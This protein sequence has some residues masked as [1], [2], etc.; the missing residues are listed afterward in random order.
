[1]LDDGSTKYDL[2]VSFQVL[3]H[4]KDIGDFLVWLKVK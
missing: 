3:E 1:M 4:V 2:I